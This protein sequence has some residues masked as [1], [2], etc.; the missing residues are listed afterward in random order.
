MNRACVLFLAIFPWSTHILAADDVIRPFSRVEE[1]KAFLAKPPIV[2]SLV[3]RPMT[4]MR[5]M[6]G[7]PTKRVLNLQSHRM[8]PVGRKRACF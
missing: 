3:L 8:K 6:P 1:F 2:R 5:Q 7:K 4:Q